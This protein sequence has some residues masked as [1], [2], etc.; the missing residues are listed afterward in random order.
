MRSKKVKNIVPVQ[1]EQRPEL[2][3]EEKQIAREQV[4]RNIEEK[5]IFLSCKEREIEGRIN[6][7]LE[8]YELAKDSTLQ[9]A[10][11]QLGVELEKDLHITQNSVAIRAEIVPKWKLLNIREQ[12]HF[13]IKCVKDD[14]KQM[15]EALEEEAEENK[16]K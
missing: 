7:Q 14:I 2:T 4:Q 12:L 5:N 10:Q 3:D 6:P 13:E 8:V 16:K 15:E 1:Q 9:S 11:N